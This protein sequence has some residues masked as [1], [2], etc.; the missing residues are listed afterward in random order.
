[1]S[2]IYNRRLFK[3]RPARAKLNQ[4]GGIMASSV[5][6]MQSVQKFQTGGGVQV[7]FSQSPLG[8]LL[9]F[10]KQ[11]RDAR[12]LERAKKSVD[13]QNYLRSLRFDPLADMDEVPVAEDIPRSLLPSTPEADRAISDMPDRPFLS[14]QAA[15]GDDAS[16]DPNQI[17]I[18]ALKQ[19][20]PEE[21]P[22]TVQRPFRERFIGTTRDAIEKAKAFERG[23]IGFDQ[24]KPGFFEDQKAAMQAEADRQAVEQR[25]FEEGLLNT[26]GVRFVNTTPQRIEDAKVITEGGEIPRKPSK[27]TKDDVRQTT[28]A[29]TPT[30]LEVELG[31]GKTDTNA[32]VNELL[33][34]TSETDKNDVILE[35]ADKKDVEEKL[36]IKQRIAKNKELAKELGLFEDAEADRKIDSFNLAFMG[37][38]IATDGLEK[39]LAKGTERMRDTAESRKKRKDLIDKFALETAFADERSE[40]QFEREMQKYDKGLQYDWLKTTKLSGDKRDIAAANIAAARANLMTKLAVDIKEGAKDRNAILRRSLYNNFDDAMS[41]AFLLAESEGLDTTSNE[42]LQNSI[43]PNALKISQQLGSSTKPYEAGTQERANLEL[44]LK[45]LGQIENLGIRIADEQGNITPE[46]LNLFGGFQSVVSG[47]D[48]P[49]PAA[50]AASPKTV[51]N[52]EE[53]DAL[54]SGTPYVD[55]NGVRS[56]KP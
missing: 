11:A 5:P 29:N 24:K 52:K 49:A 25:L 7:P 53:Y 3:P 2:N 42:V 15:F 56:V 10:N 39:G 22:R 13:I 38:A 9:G 44:F 18:A 54:P 28:I 23:E 40:K 41:A 35:A 46:P 34:L 1:M 6:L 27:K 33:G 55:S 8:R 20:A 12:A 51:T 4:M 47:Q 19:T 45:T 43:L 50:D 26:A 21:S 37:F 36:T 17:G 14:R 48:I 16:I 31:Q 30:D 32:I